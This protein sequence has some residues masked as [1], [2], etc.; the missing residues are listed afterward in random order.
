MDPA[1]ATKAYLARIAPEKKKRSDAYF[2]GRYWLR[3]WEFLYGVSV[4]WLLLRLG[5]SAWMRNFAERAARHRPAQTFIYWAQYA[6]VT[7]LLL[8]PLT[9]YRGFYREHQYGLATQTL[10]A[11]V[12]RPV[13][14]NWGSR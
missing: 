10:L 12:R 6:V 8:F 9:A 14:G 11:V 4:A 3:L 1:E 13:E 5:W 7:A 2:E